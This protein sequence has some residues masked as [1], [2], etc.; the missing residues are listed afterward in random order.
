M[1]K[2]KEP[3]RKTFCLPY[4]PLMGCRFLAEALPLFQSAAAQSVAL[5][6]HIVV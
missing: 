2:E 3:K 6:N 4:G 5:R 1:D